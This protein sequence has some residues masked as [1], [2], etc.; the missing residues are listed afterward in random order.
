MEG[1]RFQKRSMEVY[2]EERK[3]KMCIYQSKKE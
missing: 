3:V 2:K 1:M